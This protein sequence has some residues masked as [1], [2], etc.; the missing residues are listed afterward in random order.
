MSH[1]AQFSVPRRHIMDDHSEP[2][3]RPQDGITKPKR[4]YTTPGDGGKLNPLRGSGKDNAYHD[5]GLEFIERFPAGTELF[6]VKFDEFVDEMRECE[7]FR[8]R[9]DDIGLYTRPGADEPKNSD[10]YK[11]FL[12]RRAELRYNLNKASTTPRMIEAVSEATGRAGYA[13]R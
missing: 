12:Q 9:A 6:Q 13:F 8:D 1:V 2:P 7:Q 11:A 4:L 10:A 5:L 3:K